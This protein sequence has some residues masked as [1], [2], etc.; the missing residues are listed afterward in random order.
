MPGVC[1]WQGGIIITVSSGLLGSAGGAGLMADCRPVV[2]DLRT[3]FDQVGNG[4]RAKNAI[5][6]YA[7]ARNLSSLPQVTS[8]GQ[9]GESVALHHGKSVWSLT[10]Q[11]PSTRRSLIAITV[12]YCQPA[13]R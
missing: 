7:E 9:L 5:N 10:S 13:T 2:R 12:Q 4:L 6:A 3:G 8:R 11:S 1:V